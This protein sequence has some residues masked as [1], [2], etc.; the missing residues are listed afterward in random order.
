MI[1]LYI[2]SRL[3]PNNGQ[4][5]CYTADSS[6]PAGGRR[7]ISNKSLIHFSRHILITTIIMRGTKAG[8]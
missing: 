2:H 8:K 5:L 4:K 7:T 3:H 6:L 1:K